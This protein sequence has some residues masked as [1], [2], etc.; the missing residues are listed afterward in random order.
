MLTLVVANAHNDILMLTLVLAGL[1]CYLDRRYLLGVLCV[2]LATLVKFI[3]LPILLVYIALVVRKQQGLG[4]AGGVSPP[5]RW[6]WPPRSP[7]SAIC[8]YGPAAI[9]SFT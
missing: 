7:S 4:A 6:P 2:T 9:L 1:L 8:R 5:V 3:A